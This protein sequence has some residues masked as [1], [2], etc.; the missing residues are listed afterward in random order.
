MTTSKTLAQSIRI[1]FRTIDAQRRIMADSGADEQVLKA[2]TAL[3]HYL[4]K[5]NDREI[6]IILGT[7]SQKGRGSQRDEAI[8]K[9]KDLSLDEVEKLLADPEAS[10]SELE[11][12]AIGRFHVPRGSMRSIG[13]IENLREKILTFIQNERTHATISEVA[14]QNR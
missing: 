4:F 10:R 11:A 2:Y 7:A 14:K 3:V 5:L 6:A 13:N 8:S 12:I 9:A 1:V